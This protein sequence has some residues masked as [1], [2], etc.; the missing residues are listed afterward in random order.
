LL[1]SSSTAFG[2]DGRIIFCSLIV[3]Y[4]TIIL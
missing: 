1:P 4:S 2:F 3:L